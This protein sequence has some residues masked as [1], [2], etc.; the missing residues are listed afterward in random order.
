MLLI[1]VLLGLGLGGSFRNLADVQ[2]RFWPAI[3]AAVL[4]QVIPLPNME[5]QLGQVVPVGMLLLSLVI[6]LL[7]AVANWRLYGF[8]IIAVG[9]LMN[10]VVIG[11]NQGMPVSRDAVMAA[12]GADR[13]DELPREP[14]SRHH[15]AGE[16]DRLM[17]LSDVIGI[18][19]PFGVVVSVGD[20][21]TYGGATAFVVA[22]MLG[23][24]VRRPPPGWEPHHRP[25]PWSGPP[26]RT[27]KSET[28]P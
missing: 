27:R 10:F 17:F 9:V 19:P 1:G 25:H 21:L 2:I 20:L 16:E 24:P 5:G 6:L 18:R 22:A 15:L 14:G 28:Q 4:L 12:G 26:A 3:P 13:I 7:V 11:A 23:R 8:V